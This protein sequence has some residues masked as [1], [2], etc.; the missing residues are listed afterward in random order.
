MVRVSPDGRR[1]ATDI[2]EVDNDVWIWDLDRKTLS[3]A[4]FDAAAEQMPVWTPDGKRFAFRSDRAGSM[5]RVFWQAAD[6]TGQ[7]EPISPGGRAEMPFAFSPDAK[8]LIFGG[9]DPKTSQDLFV[10]SM[11]DGTT[12]P[13]LRTPSNETNAEISPDGLWM[14]YQSNE[15]GDEQ[16]YVRPFPD[17]NA[18]RWQVSTAGGTRP[19]WA[20]SGR[21]LFF[22]DPAGR[23]MA[24]PVHLTTAFD[25]GVPVVVSDTLFNPP[26]P[27]RFYDVSLDGSRFVVITQPPSEEGTEVRQVEVVL[28]W[29]EELKR[30]APPKR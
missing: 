16:V 25:S 1:L 18:G 20:K 9:A 26:T 13:L 10:R 6:G 14:A 28:N 15:T 2:R 8:W 27:G 22:L 3:R 7:A 30:L 11:I 12:R 24:T 4:T 23:L 29:G 5:L 21:E 19:V 17:V